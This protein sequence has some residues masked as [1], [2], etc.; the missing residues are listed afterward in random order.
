MIIFTRSSATLQKKGLEICDTLST[1]VHN[2]YSPVELIAS[3][4]KMFNKCIDIYLPWSLNSYSLEHLIPYKILLG[5]FFNSRKHCLLT[6]EVTRYWQKCM[7]SIRYAILRYVI[8]W[9]EVW[10]T[11][12]IFQPT[13]HNITPNLLCYSDE[14]PVR[15]YRV[16]G[17]TYSKIKQK[18]YLWWILK[19]QFSQA[20]DILLCSYYVI[21][22]VR[23][24]PPTISWKHFHFIAKT[25]PVFD[26]AN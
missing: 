7:T 20:R 1:L 26:S 24:C 15:W 13:W 19:C 21:E 17:Y 23:L 14:L 25:Q 10:K 5:F 11:T 3:P 16:L 18:I 9:P 12:V 4:L 8:S 2:K 22:Y 6:R